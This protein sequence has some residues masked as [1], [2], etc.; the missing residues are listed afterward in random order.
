MN[1]LHTHELPSLL[2]SIHDPPKRLYYHG[3]LPAF[4]Q[5]YIA[6]VGTRL[7]SDYGKRMA[8]AIAKSVTE[9]GGIVVSGLA[10]GVDGL[11]HK[12]AVD[13]HCPT[14]AVL[15]SGV[16]RVT[17]GSHI[18]LARQII[19][20]GGTLLSE[21]EAFDSAHKYRFLERNR[22]I[23]GLCKATIVIE[24]KERSGAL[25]TARHAFDQNRDV[26]A[27][28]GDIERP[29]ARG[30]LALIRDDMAKPLVS[31][32]GLLEDLGL[33]IQKERRKHLAL[34]EEE[35]LK[36]MEEKRPADTV[37]GTP[38]EIVAALSTLELMGFVE[39]GPRGKFK[40]KSR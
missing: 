18:A 7:P 14:V 11:A 5:C 34:L 3:A 16:D 37:K 32:D 6:I 13:L 17:P 8:Y 39:R 29:Q 25:I 2:R 20:N 30:C 9:A 33:D 38:A 21:Y 19:A 1:V 40:L 26:Y 35:V 27:L 4:D 15:A 24:A 10:F 23:S 36:A 28:V 31:V 22:L 12:A